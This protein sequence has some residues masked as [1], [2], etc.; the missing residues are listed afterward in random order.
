MPTM[1]KKYDIA[2]KDLRKRV[3]YVTVCKNLQVGQGDLT[4]K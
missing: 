2:A 4:N 1:N 3:K